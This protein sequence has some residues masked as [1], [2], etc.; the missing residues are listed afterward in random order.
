MLAEPDA[1]DEEQADDLEVAVAATTVSAL[2]IDELIILDDTTV[3]QVAA[4]DPEYQ[5]LVS[6]VSAGD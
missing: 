3:Q 6:K 1:M 4:E 2:A 5:L